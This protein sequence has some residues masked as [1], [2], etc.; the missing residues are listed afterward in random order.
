[1]REV[2]EHVIV[3][4]IDEEGRIVADTQG[5]S[6]DTC[7]AELERLLRNVGYEGAVVERKEDAPVQRVQS[8]RKLTLGRKKS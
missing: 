4:E 8:A 5:F 1:M 7:V 3:V 2:E 6:G